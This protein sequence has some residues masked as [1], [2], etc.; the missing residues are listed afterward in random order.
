MYTDKKFELKSNLKKVIEGSQIVKLLTTAMEQGVGCK[1]RGEYL[2]KDKGLSEEEEIGNLNELCRLTNKVLK[3]M[4]GAN[5]ESQ[6]VFDGEVQSINV[7]ITDKDYKRLRRVATNLLDIMYNLSLINLDCI[8]DIL[9]L[10]TIEEEGN[11]LIFCDVLKEINMV[12]EGYTNYDVE[13]YKYID[14]DTYTLYLAISTFLNICNGI[15]AS[16][17]ANEIDN[18]ITLVDSV[19]SGLNRLV[20]NRYVIIP[21][22]IVGY[23]K[24]NELKV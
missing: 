17:Y 21:E 15:H 11:G 20:S 10:E 4:L 8:S 2:Y 22:S 18:K 12:Y 3:T 23:I 16:K 7:K 19:P 14:E 6:A 5:T 1:L 24:I 9:F 13:S